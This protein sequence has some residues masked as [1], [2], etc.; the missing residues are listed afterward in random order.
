MYAL[1]L[2]FPGRMNNSCGNPNPTTCVFPRYAASLIG[3]KIL[4]IV[5]EAKAFGGGNLIVS[6]Q[7]YDWVQNYQLSTYSANTLRTKIV[8][9]QWEIKHGV[10]EATCLVRTGTSL[11]A[12]TI[13]QCFK[14]GLFSANYFAALYYRGALPAGTRIRVWGLFN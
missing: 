5:P 9:A 10:S 12:A 11:T 6:N 14:E 13:N 1:D 7:G 3:L 4:I 8:D 2:N